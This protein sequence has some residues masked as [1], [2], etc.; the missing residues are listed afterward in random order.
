MRYPLLLLLFGV[1]LAKSDEVMFKEFCDSYG[2]QYSSQSELRYRFEVFKKNLSLLQDLPDSTD[3]KGKVLLGSSLSSAPRK[4]Y[5]LGLNEFADLSSTEFSTYYLLP[6][7]ELYRDTEAQRR[8]RDRAG[9]WG[10]NVYMPNAFYPPQSFSPPVR[11]ISFITGRPRQLQSSPTERLKGVPRKVNWVD[12]G[13]ITPV[14]NQ[15]KCN[16]CYA[17]SSLAVVEAWNLKVN[18]K[19]DILAEQELLDCNVDNNEC[20]GGQPSAA[21]Q[22]LIDHGISYAADYPYKAKRSSRCGIKAVADANAKAKDKPANRLLQ[23]NSAAAKDA[24]K[25][26]PGDKEP[27][28]K[29]LLGFDLGPGAGGAGG[30]GG[31]GGYSP[32]SQPG[33]FSPF[34]QSYNFQQPAAFNSRGQFNGFASQSPQYQQSYFGGQMYNPYAQTQYNPFAQY[35]YQ[36]PFTPGFPFSNL[37]STKPPATPPKQATTTPF[38]PPRPIQTLPPPPPPAQTPPPRSPPANADDDSESDTD[39]NPPPSPNPPANSPPTTTP[40]QTPTPTPTPVPTPTPTP[41]PAS[42]LGDTL[43]MNP[44]ANTNRYSKVTNY[45]FIDQDVQALITEL[46]HGPVLAGFYV[47]DQLKFYQ[48][49]VFNG[50]GCDKEKLANHAILVVAYDLDAEV[51]YFTVKNSWGAKWGDQGYFKIAIGDLNNKPGFCLISGTPFNLVP[52]FDN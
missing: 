21:V 10:G 28:K 27:K 32:Y 24:A 39:T 46:A 52:E 36:N 18:K 15:A 4:P 25:S 44:S 30:F 16:S 7:E 19:S 49:G 3:T 45:R 51:P 8:G 1:A 29:V 2:K 42:D 5:R 9:T 37:P 50:D 12:E 47:P 33:G 41:T 11:G 43:D 35:S 6:K 34:G 20:K 13:I 48:S 23:D 22:Y 26:A 14:K 38:V 40:T 31:F 17:F